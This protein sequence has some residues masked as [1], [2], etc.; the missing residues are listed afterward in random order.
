MKN[1][2]ISGKKAVMASFA[3]LIWNF[4]GVNEENRENLGHSGWSSAYI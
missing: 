4:V 2:K 3:I 1:R